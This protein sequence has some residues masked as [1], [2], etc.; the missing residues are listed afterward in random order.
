MEIELERCSRCPPDAR[1]FVGPDL[2]KSGLFNYNNRRIYTHELLNQFT[3]SFSAHETPFHAFCTVVQRCYK[4]SESPIDF[5]PDDAFRTA[6]FSFTRVQ[7]LGDSFKCDVCGENP[8]VVIFDGVT[9][10]FSNKHQTSTLCPP[11]LIMPDAPVRDNLLKP[12]KPMSLVWGK[13]RADVQKAVRWRLQLTGSRSRVGGI[14]A[15]DENEQPD[16]D[17]DVAGATKQS[18]KRTSKRD[19]LDAEMRASL[20]DIVKK[21]HVLNKP[22]STMFNSF[23]KSEYDKEREAYVRPYLELLEHVGTFTFT[24]TVLEADTGSRSSLPNQLFYLFLK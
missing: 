23:V 16:A 19:V 9:A 15:D 3:N 18:K 17:V 24:M 20:P 14:E 2:C 10:G 22:L 11:T 8:P 4:G 5:V 6:F 21:L 1:Q 13:L 12:E 7:Q